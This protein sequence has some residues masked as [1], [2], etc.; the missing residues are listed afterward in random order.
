MDETSGLGLMNA[1]TNAFPA[2]DPANFFNL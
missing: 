1:E 2:C